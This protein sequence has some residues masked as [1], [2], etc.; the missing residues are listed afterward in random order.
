MGTV[1]APSSGGCG[2]ADD[3]WLT[4]EEELKGEDLPFQGCEPSP[5]ILDLGPVGL[6]VVGL[7][8][9]VVFDIDGDGQLE[10]VGWTKA[11]ADDG[12]LWMDRNGN[13]LVDSGRELFGTA[14]LLP[15][16]ELARDGFQALAILDDPLFGGN[17][18]NLVT[19]A[20]SAW[21]EV[22]VWVDRNHDAFV[23][24]GEVHSLDQL[25]IIAIEV[26]PHS[27]G[28]QDRFGNLYQYWARFYIGGSSHPQARK[29]VDVSLVLDE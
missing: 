27:S 17:G 16:R 24:T 26:V 9:S 3:A 20:D 10:V 29:I 1:G 21:Q 8:N 7:E 28:R 12:F 4:L 13:G 2:A 22:R 19:S 11:R 18:D 25:R 6:S 5:L 14:T 23:S 15:N